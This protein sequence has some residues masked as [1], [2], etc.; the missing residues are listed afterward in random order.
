VAAGGITAI[1]T[2]NS[3]TFAEVDGDA[4]VDLP[5]VE[6][7]SGKLRIYHGNSSNTLSGGNVYD[8]A[9]TGWATRDIAAIH[10]VATGHDGLLTKD[11]TTG[12]VNWYQSGRDGAVIWNDPVPLGT[13][14]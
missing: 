4:Y 8:P 6:T 3:A 10:S 12:P 13:R 7:A 9:G 2:I 14:Y 11:G 5:A 1:G